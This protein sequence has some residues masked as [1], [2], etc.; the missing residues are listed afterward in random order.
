MWLKLWK[1]LEIILDSIANWNIWKLNLK[2]QHKQFSVILDDSSDTTQ[3]SF[4]KNS[5]Y[6]VPK[7]I[8]YWFYIKSESLLREQIELLKSE[9]AIKDRIIENLSQP[10][11]TD[12][13]ASVVNKDKVHK[14]VGRR[15]NGRVLAE[16]EALD[17]ENYW[18]SEIKRRE[19]TTKTEGNVIQVDS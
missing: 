18:K 14:P 13:E 3:P 15:N 11:V 12:A 7:K 9:L 6:K 16:M 5:Q 4:A 8:D 19:E 1:R 10:I 17:R 2:S